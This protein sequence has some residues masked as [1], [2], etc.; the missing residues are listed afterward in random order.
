MERAESKDYFKADKLKTRTEKDYLIH[1]AEKPVMAEMAD[2]AGTFSE[3]VGLG[4]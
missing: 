4:L 1:L 2:E 3:A